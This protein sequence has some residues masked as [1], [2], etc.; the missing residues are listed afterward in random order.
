MAD[1]RLGTLCLVLS[2]LV[3]FQSH[4]VR[5][6]GT[7]YIRDAIPFE[8]RVSRV[9]SAERKSQIANLYCGKT[10]FSAV[11]RVISLAELGTDWC[12]YFPSAFPFLPLSR[13][14]IWSSREGWLFSGG[15]SAPGPNKPKLGVGCAVIF[16][17]AK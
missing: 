12:V 2:C 15:G 11:C 8:S 13:H 4:K 9:E 1:T 6:S 14:E 3:A 5:L 7:R 17:K 10:G 16:H